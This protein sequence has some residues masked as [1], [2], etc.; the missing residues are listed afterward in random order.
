MNLGFPKIG[1]WADNGREFRNDK[2][3]EFTKKIG[4][5]I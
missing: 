1:F 4:L 2:V 5:S 3:D